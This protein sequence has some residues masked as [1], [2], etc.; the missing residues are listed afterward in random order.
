MI[1]DTIIINEIQSIRPLILFLIFIYLAA[2]GILLQ[3]EGSL[4]VAHGLTCCMAYGILVPLPGIELAS[5]ALEGGFLTTG[6]SAKSSLILFFLYL[7][8]VDKSQV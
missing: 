3:C 6:Q 5:P 1:L 7:L 2:L 8:N 4:V